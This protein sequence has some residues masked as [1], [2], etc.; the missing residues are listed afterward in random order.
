MEHGFTYNGYWYIPIA[1]FLALSC[2]FMFYHLFRKKTRGAS[3]FI[4]PL[5]IWLC[6]CTLIALYLKGASYLI[7]PVYFGLLQLLI[8]IRVEQPNR[9][10]MV[11][12]SAPSIFFL[13]T[14][15]YSL[16]VALGLK[17]LFVT[18]ILTSLL[19]LFFLPV[20]TYFR[21]LKLFAV[22]CFLTF[23]IL[24]FIAHFYHDFNNERPKPN[25]LVYL[26]DID[27]KTATW[28]SYD[29][30]IDPWTSNFF[31][32]NAEE[33]T[34]GASNFSS[35]YGSNFTYSS[36]A[37]LIHLK[38]P[39]IELKKKQTDSSQNQWYSLKIAPNRT[40]NRLE[41][42]E[43]RNVDF[44]D[45]RVNSLEAEDIYLGE[46]RFHMF[47][48]RWRERLLTYYAD[49]MDTLRI[50]FSIK[51]DDR[52]EFVLYESAYDLLDQEQLEVP[53]REDHM[54]PRPFVLNDATI[55]KK[56]IKLN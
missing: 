40:V 24:V 45:F 19:F 34:N 25:S 51:Q 49:N 4:A 17:M 55:L 35:K 14:L 43:T 2:S 48:R 5:L 52:P 41:L 31:G 53:S 3:T 20:F 7:I 26:V 6:I 18:A 23:N 9:I 36:K 16:P 8:M 28:Y 21:K 1:I 11:L 12:L 30:M 15:I 47:T 10:L 37:P 29:E 32:K 33:T 22:L 38:Q 27:N 54:I 50:E 42:Y 39:Y 44:Q 13:L 46:N 56:T